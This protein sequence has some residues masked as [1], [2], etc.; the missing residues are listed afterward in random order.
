VGLG[1]GGEGTKKPGGGFEGLG[2]DRTLPIKAEKGGKKK[3]NRKKRDRQCK[4]HD[5]GSEN[6]LRGGKLQKNRRET[7]KKQKFRH[8]EKVL[9][10][11]KKKKGKGRRGNASPRPKQSV[12][13]IQ[14]KEEG[15]QGR[16]KE[17][18]KWSQKLVKNKKKRKLQFRLEWGSLASGKSWG[19]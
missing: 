16:G 6:S 17:K 8:R 15:E 1:G 7:K 11:E 19:E 18:R 3:K 14:G 9:G 5:R 2:L 4:D 12:Q 10:G 13:R